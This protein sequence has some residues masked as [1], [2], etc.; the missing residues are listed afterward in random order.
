MKK[1][2]SRQRGAAALSVTLLLLFV[3]TLVVGFASRNLL[4]EQ[5]GGQPGALDA[6]LRGRRGRA[7]VGTSDARQRR[8]DRCRLQTE[9]N[10]RRSLLS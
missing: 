8:T 5:R 4:F 2:L 7:R 9:H 3:L 6:G 1:S 10:A